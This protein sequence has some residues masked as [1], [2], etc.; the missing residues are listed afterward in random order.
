MMKHI[1][2]AAFLFFAISVVAQ[3]RLERQV[4]ASQGASERT[5]SIRL[6]WTLGEPAV[7]TLA[8]PSGYWTEG[9]QQP[10]LRVERLLPE[11]TAPVAHDIRIAPNPTSALL[12]VQFPVSL[13]AELVLELFD[14]YGKY[15]LRLHLPEPSDQQIDLGAFP[16][17]IYLLRC[18]T[19]QGQPLQTFRIVKA[20]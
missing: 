11:T 4:L 2:T 20:K 6:D 1:L 13:T 16:S 7:S 19:R 5:E 14:L 10:A 8:T 12:H 3:S 15:L 17:G 18:S 9:Y